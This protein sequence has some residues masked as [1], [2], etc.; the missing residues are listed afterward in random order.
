M[1]C[2]S[3]RASSATSRRSAESY[4]GLEDGALAGPEALKKHLAGIPIKVRGDGGEI[5]LRGLYLELHG[6]QTRMP[7]DVLVGALAASLRPRLTTGAPDGWPASMPWRRWTAGAVDDY[8]KGLGEV[9]ARKL[10][11]ELTTPEA[12]SRAPRGQ[13]NL[14]LIAAFASRFGSHFIEQ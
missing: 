13:L 8:I 7:K 10:Y 5:S 6:K 1:A 2:G 9:D 12:A 11:G 3:S 4:L 14:S